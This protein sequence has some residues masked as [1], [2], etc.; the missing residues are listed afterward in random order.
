RRVNL[1]SIR[2]LKIGNP[3]RD[4]KPAAYAR[5]ARD[6]AILKV[7]SLNDEFGTEAAQFLNEQKLG[8]S[9]QFKAVIEE[10]DNSGGKVKGQG[11]GT[12]LVVTLFI[13]DSEDSINA[14]MLKEEAKTGRRRM[15]QYGD[16]ES[17]DEDL[18]PPVAAKK[19]G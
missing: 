12:C 9:L 15:W 16:V 10:R 19:I 14:T 17:N 13:E 18:L 5:G 4:E 6:L 11:I 2:C 8:S 1:S 7:P 3:R